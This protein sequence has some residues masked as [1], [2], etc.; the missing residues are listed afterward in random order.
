MPTDKSP[1]D[2]HDSSGDGVR[3]D[4]LDRGAYLIPVCAVDEYRLDR[5]VDELDIDYGGDAIEIGFNVT[6]LVDVLANMGQDIVA[7][8][9]QREPEVLLTVDNGI[10]S[11]DGV[12]QV[13]IGGLLQRLIYLSYGLAFLLAFIGVKLILHA[14]HEN[15]LPFINGG[16]HVSVPEISTL[17]S[18]GAIVVILGVT[19]V[20][21]LWKSNK[22]AKQGI[23]SDH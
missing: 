5:V 6:Y 14:L 10:S 15:T 3:A 17:F 8:A 9:L 23:S 22:D 19:T 20:A 18:L 21:S 1:I 16:E 11:L 4:L 13:R 7:V 12:A 2:R